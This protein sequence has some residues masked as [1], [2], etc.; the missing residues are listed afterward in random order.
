MTKRIFHFFI[1][2]FF[3]SSFLLSD[4]NSA[5]I[6]K[7]IIS[8]NKELDK[9]RKDIINVE[10][11]LNTKIKQAISTT[12]ILINLENKIL[13]TEKLIKSLKKE[14]R[15][16]GEL[17]EITKANI[18]KKE[19]YISTLREQMSHRVIYIYKNGIPSLAETILTSKNWNEIIYRTK[20]LKVITEYEKKMITEIETILEELNYEKEN[21]ES[22][23]KKKKNLR[24]EHQQESKKLDSD[25]KKK[26]NLL[27]Q[28]KNDKINLQE[29][30]AEKQKSVKEIEN[31]IS[32][33]QNDEN[34]MK[35][36][37]AELAKIRSEKKK[38]TV[39]NFSSLK[40][41]MPWPVEGKIIAHFGT[42][43]NKELNT[44]T[45]NS[46]IDIQVSPGTPVESILD[47]MITT[48]TY[49]RG[50]G[51]LII[52]DHGD[53]YFS[54]YANIEKIQFTEGDYIQQYSVLGYIP[55]GKKEIS[56]LHF[57]IW[58]NNIK[59]NPE[60]WLKKK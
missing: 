45:E 22:G 14:E 47:G 50:Y 32:K 10:K 38:A 41:R 55:K 5:S 53:S 40:G 54:V 35:R 9:L 12:E 27:I 31:L 7:D 23:L 2:L 59:L 17:V 15:Y 46:G 18:A 39:G 60:K 36:R 1:F 51:N 34:E 28:I 48:I 13:L 43:K 56:R 49:L 26:N 3:L 21:F 57:E 6:R 24:K 44:V 58:G 42:Q 20:Y 52:I 25:K 11:N 4:K 33:L 16:I 30:L 8:Q 37:E 19:S 29:D